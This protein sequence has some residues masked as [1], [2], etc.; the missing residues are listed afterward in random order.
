[1]SRADA[2]MQGGKA[3]RICRVDKQGG[4]AGWISRADTDIQGRKAGRICRADMQGR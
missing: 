1:M 3:G 2:D 4:Y